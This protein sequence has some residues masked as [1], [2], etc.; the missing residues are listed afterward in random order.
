MLQ[1]LPR[2]IL[3]M[4]LEFDVERLCEVSKTLYDAAIRKLY[5]NIVI[6]AEDDWH[7]ERV[8][9]EPFSRTRFKPT[10]PLDYVRIV[11]VQSRFYHCLKERCFY[12]KDMGFIW[13]CLNPKDG[14]DWR[15]SQR[16]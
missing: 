15:I 12:Y 2:D 14:R 11:Q 3:L 10:S 13:E 4:I 9:V 7:F 5:E 1:K 6:R 8:E 16:P